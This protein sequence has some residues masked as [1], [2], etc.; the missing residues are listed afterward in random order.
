MSIPRFVLFLAAGGAAAATNFGSRILL[1]EVL[2][3]VPAIVIAYCIGMVTAF[4]LNRVFVFDESAN[5]LGRQAGWFLAVNVA[6][7]AQTVLI[8]L[9]F[10]R[11]VFPWAGI[12]TYPEAIAHGIG[13]IVPVFTSYLGHKHLTFRSTNSVK[14]PSQKPRSFR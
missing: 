5:S 7:V 14:S 10:A 1:S 12:E 4:I 13:V 3:Y 8:S 6:A 9:L 2:A 11:V